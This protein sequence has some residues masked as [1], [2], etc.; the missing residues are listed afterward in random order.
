MF[1]K[2]QII[3]KI[4]NPLLIENGMKPHEFAFI[5]LISK[6]FSTYNR[7]LFQSSTLCH[8][9]NNYILLPF[10]YCH[11]ICRWKYRNIHSFD[12]F[13]NKI[14]RYWYN[15]QIGRVRVSWIW[16]LYTSNL[17]LH[18]FELKSSTIE[19]QQAKTFFATLTLRTIRIAD[20]LKST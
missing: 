15:I 5:G 8:V 13:W 11:F 6:V 14:L 2:Y 12:L 18:T 20:C 17:V 4:I 1:T 3:M 9:H 10:S 19:L 7:V 16:N